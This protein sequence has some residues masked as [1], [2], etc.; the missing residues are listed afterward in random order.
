MIMFL[1]RRVRRQHAQMAR[2]A[3]VDDQGAVRKGDQQVF[4]APPGVQDAPAGQQRR[5][6]GRE[7]PAQAVAAH[8]HAVDDAPFDMR[9]DA[10]PGDFNFWQFWHV[11]LAMIL[12]RKYGAWCK[13]ALQARTRWEGSA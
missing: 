2:H 10:A 13:L 7:G 11:D 6:A 4:A 9:R 3:E 8:Q 1:R 12:G 5:Q